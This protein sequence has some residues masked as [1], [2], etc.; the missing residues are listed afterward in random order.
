MTW[1]W[2]AAE[3]VLYIRFSLAGLATSFREDMNI[4]VMTGYGAAL[5]VTSW[6]RGVSGMKFVILVSLCA[7]MLACELMN[8][9]MERICN[10]ICPAPDPRI[11]KIKD[12]SSA[13]VF[14]PGILFTL[15]GIWWICVPL[16]P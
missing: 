6:L 4:K 8:T 12:I 13:A 3:R 5:I 9:A 7:V 10:F 14:L 16:S 11:K 1:Y 15:L 2:R